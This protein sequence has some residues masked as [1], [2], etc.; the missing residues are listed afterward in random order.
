MDFR[1]EIRLPAGYRGLVNHIRP[2]LLMGSCFSDNIGGC[3]LSALFNT[4]V[5]PFGPLYNPLSVERAVRMVRDRCITDRVCQ[6]VGHFYSYDAHSRI[7][8]CDKETLKDMFSR[9]VEE[10][11]SWFEKS[12]VVILTLG[13]VR[14]F[15]LLSDGL[16]VANCHKQS[17]R[18]F[19]EHTLSLQ[20]TVDSLGRTI[21]MIKE[22][23]PESEIILTVSPLRYPG[24][25]PHSNTVSKSILHLAVEE[26]TAKHRNVIY[27]PAYEIMMDD[28]RDYRFYA[29][30][31]RHPSAKAVEY[32]YE[33]FSDCFFDDATAG[34][35]SAASRLTRR[36]LHRSTEPQDMASWKEMDVIHRYPMLDD[37]FNRFLNYG[38]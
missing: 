23:S 7:C 34:I 2:V 3:L 22:M 12:P 9:A 28:L 17:G 1:T 33:K 27:F 38:N 20:E 19:R 16:P 6:D 30:D 36:A 13:T 10:T 24:S 5:N 14:V 25:D 4:L 32:I 35:A 15:T 21:G 26:M 31:M 37:A 29:D 11:R 8:A 18:L